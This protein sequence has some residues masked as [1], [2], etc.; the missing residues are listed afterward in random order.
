[1]TTNSL[2]YLQQQDLQVTTNTEYHCMPVTVIAVMS[3]C[4]RG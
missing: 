4:G 2:E 1:M 3:T